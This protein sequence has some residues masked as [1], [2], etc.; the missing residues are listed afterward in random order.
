[1]FTPLEG[2]RVTTYMCGPTVYD[3]THMG[4]ARTYIMFD[5][6]RR[7]LR[8]YFHYDLFVSLRKLNTSDGHEHH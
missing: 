1:M 8:D 4:H 5:V 7:L 6:I 3:Y 2:N